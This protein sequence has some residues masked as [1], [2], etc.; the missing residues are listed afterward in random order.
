MAPAHD[1]TLLKLALSTQEVAHSAADALRA[2]NAD[3]QTRSNVTATALAAVEKRLDAVESRLDRMEE[4]MSKAINRLDTRD[5]VYR[6]ISNGVLEWLKLRWVSVLIGGAIVGSGSVGA[7]ML[8]N[9][10]AQIVSGGSP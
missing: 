1:E 6:D 8:K 7:V 9:A 4:T 3:A 5:Q 10:L 2:A